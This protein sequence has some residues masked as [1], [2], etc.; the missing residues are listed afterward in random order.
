MQQPDSE[1]T[2]SQDDIRAD[3]REVSRDAIRMVIE[4]VMENAVNLMVGAGRHERTESRRDTRNGSYPRHIT[5]TVGDVEIDV[6]RT[7]TRG[8][9]SAVISRYKRRVPELDD[10]ITEAYVN[11]T[12]TRKV[13]RITK[14]L[15]GKDVGRSTVSRVTAKLQ[16]CVDGL[17]SA[18]IDDAIIYLYLE[19][20]RR[21]VH[22]K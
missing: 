5:T 3:L 20:L 4:T 1:L 21:W 22:K 9:A 6:P 15:L 18:P 17:R 8:A 16:K 2:P 13:T 14:A 19:K 10:A 7:R 11:G 12:S